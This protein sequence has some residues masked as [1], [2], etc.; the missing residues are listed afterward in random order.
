MHPAQIFTLLQKAGLSTK[1]EKCSFGRKENKYFGFKLTQEGVER[2]TIQK[3]VVPPP[4]LRN[5]KEVAEFVG[6]TSWYQ[7]FI[8][9]FAE[10]WEKLYQFKRI[11]IV[12]SSEA[13]DSCETFKQE[14]MKAA[15]L[16][17][18]VKNEQFFTDGLFS[19][20]KALCWLKGKKQ[21]RMHHGCYISRAELCNHGEGVPCSNLGS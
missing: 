10:L 2:L 6:M 1:L 9:N 7:Q 19:R 14:L 8:S 18:P 11:K 16:A 12:W 3:Q 4:L 5:A 20:S 21:S 15:M 17:I 13:Q